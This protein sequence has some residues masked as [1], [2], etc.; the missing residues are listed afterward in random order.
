MSQPSTLKRK[1]YMPNSWN[2]PG[3]PQSLKR[4][5]VLF[6][7]LMVS[8]WFS[9]FAARPNVIVVLSDDQGYGD[10]AANGNSLIQTPNMD[11][12]HDEGIR[13]TDFHVDPTCSP[14]RSALM[15]GHY[16][17]NAGVWH[18]VAGRDLLR[19]DQ[20]TMA[21]VFAD[22]GYKTA[23]FGKWHLGENYPLRP[24]DRG[25]QEALVF[26]G[27]PLGAFFKDGLC[28][29]ALFFPGACFN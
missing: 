20:V 27:G 29:A 11:K 14:T 23:I 24:Q 15:T 10:I 13:F 8:G 28:P 9:V 19:H 25:F 17:R 7:L 6:L 22:N 18:T 12:L 16:S 1:K 3:V 26:K 4:G 5:G 2:S 21:R